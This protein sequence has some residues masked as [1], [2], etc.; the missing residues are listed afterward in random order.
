MSYGILFRNFLCREGWCVR[1][2]VVSLVPLFKVIGMF[3]LHN[4]GIIQ[5]PLVTI[6]HMVQYAAPHLL[7]TNFD[8]HLDTRYQIIAG[9][10]E[11][12]ITIKRIQIRM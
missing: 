11:T 3:A 6:T 10:F 7:D 2:Q 4:S 8:E 12:I 5:H 9:E 1:F